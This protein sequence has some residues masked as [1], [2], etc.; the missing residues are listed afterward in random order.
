MVINELYHPKELV[1]I[2][3]LSKH[4]LLGQGK[5]YQKIYFKLITD[6]IL[7]KTRKER[8]SRIYGIQ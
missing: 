4:Y 7:Y 2:T 6:I 3:T 5:G 1:K 8:G